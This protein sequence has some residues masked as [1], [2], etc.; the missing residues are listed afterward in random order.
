M[1]DGIK[2]LMKKAVKLPKA[3]YEFLLDSH[4]SNQYEKNSVI[5]W[6]ELSFQEDTL[7]AI[8]DELRDFKHDAIPLTQLDRR[9]VAEIR[10]KTSKVNRNNVTRTKA[11][12]DFYKRHPEIHWSFLAH[13]VSRNG[14]WNMTDLKGSILKEVL[15]N[16]AQNDFF[17]F[18]ERANAL[19][20][21]DAYPQLLLYEASKKRNK[22]LFYLLPKLHVSRF[23]RPF[24]NEFFEHK[25]SQLLTVAL[26]IN[27]QHYIEK[28]VVQHPSY[29]EKVL[30]NII[31][32]L[33]DVLQF[34]YVL[35]PFV[36]S[37]NQT[38]LAGVTVSDFANIRHRI[39]IG[40]KL[41]CLLFGIENLYNDISKFTLKMQ[42]TGSR[43]DYWTNMFTKNSHEKLNMTSLSCRPKKPIA[44]SPIL[45]DVWQDVSHT[46]TDNEDWFQPGNEITSF[47][48][49]TVTPASFDL[50]MQYCQDVHKM[51]VAS[52]AMKIVK[53]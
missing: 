20:F 33:Q 47:F 40:K 19:I 34:T 2:N 23:M 48:S 8:E 21:H 50:T 44:H 38:R 22:N 52:D 49:T 42:H 16:D 17:S 27:E 26:I 14:G 30:N 39:E 37:K 29:K 1:F 53:G 10:K 32:K 35:F 24:W 11:Y 12:F 4:E 43:N 9:L 5:R 18:L 13:L 51:M 28:R 41:Y 15:S 46:F 6:N 45:V 25:K 3:G 7:K 31:F 36:T